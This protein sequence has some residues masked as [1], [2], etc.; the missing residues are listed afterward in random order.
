MQQPWTL[1]SSIFLHGSLIHLLYNMFALAL[2]G[3]I[4]ENEIGSKKFLYVYFL[5]GLIASLSSIPFYNAVLGASGAIFGIMGALVIL[6]PKMTIWLYG[7]PLPMYLASLV[8]IGIDLIGIF[9]PGD[10]ANIAHLSGIFI[11]IMFGLI[12]RSKRNKNI[13]ENPSSDLDMK[14]VQEW[15]D[16]HMK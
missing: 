11:G 12:F 4:L 7:I 16:K 9:V 1:I 10:T 13:K 6:K 15:E 5:S 3:L 8:W 2:F 14:T